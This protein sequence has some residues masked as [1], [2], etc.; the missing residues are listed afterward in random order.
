MKGANIN[1]VLQNKNHVI[2]KYGDTRFRK[3]SSEMYNKACDMYRCQLE[4]EVK[5]GLIMSFIQ[6]CRA[7]VDSLEAVGGG[8]R[9]ENTLCLAVVCPIQRICVFYPVLPQVRPQRVCSV[10]YPA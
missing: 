4:R 6:G 5:G 9:L 1:G 7:A 3:D 10:L 2:T 8:E